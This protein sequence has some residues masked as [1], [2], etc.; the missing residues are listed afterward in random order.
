MRKMTKVF[1]MVST[2]K[3]NWG[4]SIVKLF[5][6]GEETERVEIEILT[7]T[8][9]TSLDFWDGNWIDSN[10]K[11]VIP[12]Y[13]VHFPAHLRTDELRD[14]LY[15]LKS[16]NRTLKG[17]AVLNNLDHYIHIESEINNLG[18]INWKGETCYPA[19][20]GARLNFEFQSNQSYLH[21]II[22]ELEAILEIYPVIGIP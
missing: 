8:H 3:F 19:G 15:E 11:V 7:R 14:F 6:F 22:K 21:K 20:Y 16:M 13:S 10:I 2:I 1:L 5:L 18:H 17:S 4:W 12:G 9:P